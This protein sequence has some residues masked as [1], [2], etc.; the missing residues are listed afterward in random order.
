[1]SQPN[2]NLPFNNKRYGSKVGFDGR[3]E[4]KRDSRFVVNYNGRH[5][6]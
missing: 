6:Y 1:M 4:R 5:V 3:R 2:Y